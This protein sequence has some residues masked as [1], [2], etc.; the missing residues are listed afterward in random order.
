MLY[1]AKTLI[2]SYGGPTCTNRFFCNPSATVIVLGHTHYRPEY[3]Y[4]ND[5]A[6]YW[7]VRHSH[8]IPVNKQ[9]FLLDFANS[10]DEK[11]VQEILDLI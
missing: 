10:L 4:K 3:E 6:M 11:N 2:F 7:H 8:L 9:Y 1:H 5:D